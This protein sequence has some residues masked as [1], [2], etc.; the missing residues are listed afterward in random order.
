MKRPLRAAGPGTERADL[1]KQFFPRGVPDLWCPSLTHYTLDGAIDG[2]RI[3]AHLRHLSPSVKGFLIPGSTSDGWELTEKEFWTLL[4]IALEQAR[5]LELHLLIGV[6]KAD[7]A[8][9]LVQ[10][11][12]VLEY[13]KRKSRQTDRLAAMAQARVCGLAICAPRGHGVSQE[14][15][16]RG[17]VPVLETGAPVALYQLP[18]MTL[19]EIG[20]ELAVTLAERF[21]NFL[22]F[23]DTSGSDR[24]VLS[25]ND[26]GGVFMMRG[27]E[28]DYLRWLKAAGGS[29]DG[30]LLS[31]ANCLASELSQMIAH[32]RAGE[33]DGARKLSEK[34]TA[35]MN[36]VF[37]LV[38]PVADGNVYANANKAIDHF[39]AHGRRATELAGPRLHAGSSL[40]NAVVQRTGEILEKY[41][42]RPD[43]GYVDR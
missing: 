7:A 42:V 35:I 6:L 19:N 18:Q 43:H 1:L 34:V 15:I 9:A 22:L 21:P 3:A 2:T 40:P 32:A 29:Y 8:E 16:E 14:E 13:L 24:V 26:L 38:R 37:E 33:L 30:F 41:G 36:E 11:E 12:K 31:T 27:A 17:L 4:E 5:S 20:P 25:G 39:L 23:K 10:A 28:G